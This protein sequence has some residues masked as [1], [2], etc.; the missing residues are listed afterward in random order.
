MNISC[1]S[2]GPLWDVSGIPALEGLF[3]TVV[4]QAAECFQRWIPLCYLF[5]KNEEFFLVGSRG[6]GPLEYNGDGGGIF[7]VMFQPGAHIV[8]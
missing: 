5:A 4:G 1:L 2:P 6:Y 3:G 8:Q 7:L